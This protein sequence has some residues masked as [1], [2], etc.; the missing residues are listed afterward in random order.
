MCTNWATALSAAVM[1]SGTAAESQLIPPSGVAGPPL[2]VHRCTD[3]FHLCRSIKIWSLDHTQ[4]ADAIALS[5]RY[6]RR[7]VEADEVVLFPTLNQL[8]PV[9]STARDGQGRLHGMKYIDC[10]RWYGDCVLS[11]SCDYKVLLWAPD[12]QRHTVRVSLCTG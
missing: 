9:F 7:G 4:M 3:L 12:A 5:S 10:V 11:M 6:G 8:E 2:T 1:T